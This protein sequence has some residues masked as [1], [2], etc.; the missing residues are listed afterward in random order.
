MKSSE[1]INNPSELF[2]AYPTPHGMSL[3]RGRPKEK[4][5]YAQ[6]VYIDHEGGG[7]A[8]ESIPGFRKI[9][10]TEKKIHSFALV[11]AEEK[12]CLIVHEGDSLYRSFMTEENEAKKKEKLTE[13]SDSES[14]IFT[15][16]K[17][18]IITDGKSL[19]LLE[20]GEITA[21][22]DEEFIAKC[23]LC[24][25]VD[26]RLFL[27]GNKNEGGKIFFSSRLDT[28][29]PTFSYEDYILEGGEIISLL[30][31]GGEL[32]VF[33]GGQE[34]ESIVCRN[35]EE[36]YQKRRVL[37]GVRPTGRAL[38]CEGEIVFLAEDGLWS[39]EAPQ[40]AEKARLTH[41]SADID[42][43][44]L[45]EDI[46]NAPLTLWKGYVAIGVG[47]KIY[48]ADRREDYSW[49]ILSDIGSYAGDR[50]VYRYSP[51]APEG[52][53]VHK[54]TDMAAEGEV[55]SLRLEDGRTVYYTEEGGKR[56]A[57][58]PTDE[59]VGGMFSPAEALL[60]SGSLLLFST[61]DGLFLFNSD[62]RGITPEGKDC[63]SRKKYS[64]HSSFYSFDGHAPRYIIAT[65]SDDCGQSLTEK[66]SLGRSL[67]LKLKS[68]SGAGL[69]VSVITDGEL[70]S[71][72]TVTIPPA[73]SAGSPWEK[74]SVG[75]KMNERAH[76]WVEKQIVIEG[77]RF[78]SPFGLY[79]LGFRYQPKENLRKDNL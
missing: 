7:D 68:P 20:G 67:M 13:L 75:V 18:S 24:A 22:F 5:R 76:G 66:T 55:M 3:K 78:A 46:K 72:Q 10:A 58:Y 12:S 61:V 70:A 62:K 29:K 54:A 65:E 71:R 73:K 79:S 42:A 47:E 23:S 69:T 57:V 52:Y 41:R 27:S 31:H 59:R 34:G 1:R 19:Y 25:M 60:S 36:G 32:W 6:N 53:S 40:S 33:K 15:F 45:T 21:A 37:C 56:Y 17:I 16:G 44:L 49:Y 39:I 77:Q 74:E 63:K 9:Y 26:G 11:K 50:R 2:R 38:S 28:E 30:S 51:I 64:L 35:T 43:M 8:V 4:L 14:K 48:L